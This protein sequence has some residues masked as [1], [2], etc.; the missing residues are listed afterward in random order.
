[1]RWSFETDSDVLSSPAVGEDGTIYV[2]S[3]DG[4]LY[5]I[6][7]N[8]TEE[9]SVH[10]DGGDVESSPAIGE[11]GTI[12]VGLSYHLH[13]ECLIAVDAETGDIEWRADTGSGVISSPVIG[14]D[15]TI[16]VA[17]T[18]NAMLWAFDSDGDEE[19]S[20]EATGRVESSPAIGEDGTIYFGSWGG[21][22]YAVDSD[23]DEEWVFE[24]DE[25]EVRIDSSPAIGEDGTIYVGLGHFGGESLVA[26]NPD[27]GEEEWR[28]EPGASVESSP[29][30]GEDGTIYV[31]AGDDNLYAIDPDD[32]EEIWS[33]ETD[34]A[35][36]SS[37]AI[38]ADGTIYVGDMQ[39]QDGDLYAVN[40]DGTEKWSFNTD[41]RI[42]S[43]PAIGA[44][45]TIY[46]GSRDNNLYAITGEHDLTINIEGE[47]STD[48]HE[49]THTYMH[50][51]E[52]TVEATPDEGWYFVEWTGDY[53]GTEED[54]T[55]MIE[56]DMEI[57]AHFE[58]YATL[59]IDDI[60]G[61][62][63]VFVD[64]VPVSAGF[65]EDY[66]QGTDVNL[67]AEADL[68]WYFADWEGIP[69]EDANI[70]ITMEEDVTITNAL[71]EEYV[72]L[73]ITSTEG[74]SVTEPGEGPFE[75]YEQGEVVDLIA[76]SEED[77]HFVEWTGD[78]ETI[79]DKTA[80]ET[81]IEMND[82]YEIE[83]NFAE[84][85]IDYVNIYPETDQE[86]EAGEE[87]EFTAE[88]IDEAGQLITD[89]V[90]QFEWENIHEIDGENNVAIFYNE[91][92]GEYDVTAEYDEEVS[93][94]TTVTVTPADVYSVTIVPD[95]DQYIEAGEEL[96]FTAEAEDEYENFI[97]DDVTDFDW[98]NIYAF[99]EEN[100]LAIFYQ[101]TAGEY[102]VTAEYDGE[103]SE[104]TTVTVEPGDADSLH[105]VEYPD[106]LTAGESFELVIEAR[107]EYGNPAEDQEIENFEIVSEFDGEVY[108]EEIIE[109][110]E[111]GQYEAV[112]SE[113]E[114]ITAND[115]HTVSVGSNP[116]EG[117]SVD[118]VVGIAE[119][120]HVEIYPYQYQIV[121]YVDEELNFTAKATDRYGNVLEDASEFEWNNTDEYGLFKEDTT[122]HFPVNAT[123]QGITSDTTIVTV[124]LSE[125]DVD[126]MIESALEPYLT[127]AEINEILEG[128]VSFEDLTE[129]LE[130]Y[131][132]EAEINNILE[133][134][135]TTEDLTEALEPYLTETEINNILEDYVDY[136][137]LTEA[138]APY[139]SQSEINEL[140]EDYITSENFIATLED[141][142]TEDE[143]DD[144]LAEIEREQEKVD[145]EQDD[146]IGMARNLG[147]VGIILAIL[148]VIIAIVAMQKK[149]TTDEEEPIYE[150]EYEEEEPMYE[151]EEPMY[152]EEEPM[153][154]EEQMYDEDEEI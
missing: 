89:D 32:G 25:D 1:M 77:Y 7:P 129:A 39:Y 142:L 15:G 35:V 135:I 111:Y 115:E 66:E 134:Y 114:V 84:T 154:E 132:T 36:I 65:T 44:D 28:F 76:D 98:D 18:N 61:E 70:T 136:P 19:W 5:A 150:E 6:N 26:I 122:D 31:G 41:G 62:G 67:S 11:D 95:D 48:P 120:E 143:I 37:P 2:G 138:L 109:L 137:G 133:A 128:Y 151:E 52:I 104:P 86:V 16:Y 94:P 59:T 3:N 146:D 141:Y 30:I 103:V 97:T 12:Y 29:A 117:D 69:E 107:D 139:L 93:E 43:S 101:E 64:D 140:L 68:D 17:S 75:E 21:N 73:T 53:E 112:V 102:E 40:P 148:A 92:V 55:F 33:F 91:T 152:E 22:L 58:E 10:L 145:E 20:Y 56:D 113:D 79:A 46:F 121:V 38:G 4:Y 153:Y 108:F 90:T 57:T 83:A 80:A 49:G 99:D 27:N 82:D 23:G 110:D 63:T 72:S 54:I 87:L 88:A 78:N 51:E 71:F 144:V 8:G 119:I 130:P 116:I 147:L 100:N 124:V 96:N 9:W 126:E 50:G 125:S 118:I 14:E 149:E 123:Y 47:G 74:G 13:D 127:E 60:T 34:D 42:R 81:T 106:T 105:I 131:L 45:G 85:H 24:S